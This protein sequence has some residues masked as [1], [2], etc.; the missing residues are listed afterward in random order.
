[1]QWEVYPEKEP[2]ILLASGEAAIRKGLSNWTYDLSITHEKG[3]KKWTS[4]L[5][6]NDEVVP[7]ASDNGILYLPP[8]KYR[9]LLKDKALEKEVWLEVTQKKRGT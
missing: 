1:M 3:K 7:T 4:L 6:K 8:G 9:I 2:G 5:Q